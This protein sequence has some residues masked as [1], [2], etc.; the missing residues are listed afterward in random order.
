M[1]MAEDNESIYKEMRKSETLL[2]RRFDTI[3]LSICTACVLGMFGFL[4]SMNA[5]MAVT[6]ERYRMSQDIN[7]KMQADMNSIRL[8]LNALK[9]TVVQLQTEKNE[10]TNAK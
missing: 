2:E 9:L 10:R 7:V 4:W 3:L 5:R 8:D 1:T 6:E